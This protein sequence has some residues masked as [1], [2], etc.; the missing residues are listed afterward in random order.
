MEQRYCTF[1]CIRVNGPFL[2]V[3]WRCMSMSRTCVGVKFLSEEWRKHLADVVR[4]TKPLG[5][6]LSGKGTGIYPLRWRFSDFTKTN[7]SACTLLSVRVT[8]VSAEFVHSFSAHQVNSRML[9]IPFSSMSAPFTQKGNDT[10]LRCC[11]KPG[12]SDYNRPLSTL[13]VRVCV[14]PLWLR[15]PDRNRVDCLPGL[16]HLDPEAVWTWH[17]SWRH[18]LPASTATG[19]APTSLTLTKFSFLK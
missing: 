14:Q 9:K 4:Q 11:K 17:C 8:P 3:W 5:L 10:N 12:F 6:H 15:R 7:P 19:T 2:F 13:K 1:F 16:A 18:H